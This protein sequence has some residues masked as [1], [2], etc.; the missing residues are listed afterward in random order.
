MNLHR[1][2]E[3]RGKGGG[4]VE[5]KEQMRRRDF[6]AKLAKG[7][8]VVYANGESGSDGITRVSNL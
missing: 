5:E 1:N 8:T 2:D 7:T 4:K 6:A 3:T